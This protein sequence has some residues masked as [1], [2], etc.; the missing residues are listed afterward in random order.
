[1]GSMSVDTPA[2]PWW[3]WLPLAAYTL[4]LLVILLDPSA[5]TAS[6]SVGWLAARFDALGLPAALIAGARV[7]FAVN[8][9][10]F[11]PVPVLAALARPRITGSQ[12]VTGLFVAS[13]AVEAVQAVLLPG[14]SAQFA[15]VVANTLGGCLGV[16]ALWLWPIL[17]EK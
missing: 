12:W 10:M 1:M 9:L 8:A 13:L 7:E 16:A 17:R 15:D 6:A 3:R 11:A 5:A 2:P 14:R 4:V